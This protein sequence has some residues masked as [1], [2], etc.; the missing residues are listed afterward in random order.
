MRRSDREV[1][2]QENILAI[3][4]KCEVMRLGLC[5]GNQPYI[6]PMNFAYNVIDGKVNIYFHCASE[7][8]KLDMIEKNSNVC[9][10]ADCSFKTLKAENACNWSAEF[11][12]VVGEG[13]I[14]VITDE[15]QKNA[16]LDMLMKRYGFEGKPSYKPQA[17]AAVTILQ[18]SVASMTGKSK[19]TKP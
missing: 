15:L 8:K 6:V 9:F 7:G 18:I 14:F 5:V 10:E 1:I 3:L 2:G 16:V 17:V 4:D 19:V 13:K 12:S 11:Q